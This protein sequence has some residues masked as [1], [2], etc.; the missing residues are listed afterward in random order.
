[1]KKTVILAEIL[2]VAAGFSANAE[3]I[4]KDSLSLQNPVAISPANLINGRISGIKVTST[5]GG[6]NSIIN[7]SIRGVNS[8]RGESEPLWIVDGVVINNSIRQN[9]D[10]FW[11]DFYNG[12]HYS[13]GV[14]GMNFIAPYDIE[15][16]EVLK[17]IS[18]TAIYGSR[19]AN[20]VIIVNTKRGETEKFHLDWHSNVGLNVN[21]YNGISHNHVL[22]GG[23]AHGGNIYSVS[24]FFRT[25][26]GSMPREK[27]NAGG[28]NLKFES[29]ANKLFHFGLNA[30]I[31]INNQNSTSGVARYGA[32]SATI[33]K[34]LQKDFGS[35]GTDFD[36]ETRDYRALANA[37]LD[38]NFTKQLVWRTSMGVSYDNNTR[39]TWYGAGTPIGAE[40]NGAASILA[41]SLLNF[42]LNTNLSYKV[43]ISTWHHLEATAGFEYVRE[44]NIFNNMD[45]ADFFSHELRARGLQLTSEKAVI[46]KFNH[47][48]GHK[49]FFGSLA[50]DYKGIA[51]LSGSLRADNT[52]RYDDS[53]FILYPAGNAW[54]DLHRAFFP[55]FN[56][57]SGLKLTGG[58]GKSGREIYVP[59]LLSGI[60]YTADIALFN[61]ATS[62]AY[63]GFNRITSSEWN[64]GV[65]A[66]FVGNRILFRAK[67]FEK[68]TKD[69][70]QIF[71]FGEPTGDAG[72]WKYIARQTAAD[73]N[74]EIRN[75]GYEFDL[76]VKIINEKDLSWSVN[77][78]ATLLSNQLTKV[79]DE[80]MFGAPICT[81]GSFANINAVGKGVSALYG[82]DTDENGNL[83]DHNGD[84][85]ITPDDRIWL[86]NVQ[87]QF[88]AGLGSSARI[89]RFTADILFD[90]S[91]GGNVLNLGR[92][93][94]EGSVFIT[95][96]QV[97]RND[98]LRCSK[99]SL[100]YAVPVGKIKWLNSLNVNFI[101]NNPF[102]ISGYSGWNPDTDCF[103]VNGF[104]RGIDY[105]TYP[106]IRTLML[107]FSAKF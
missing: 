18:A 87:P 66:S 60:Y 76:D 63:D 79:A 90:A 65:E 15:S 82:F 69:A 23:S 40:K 14:N 9:L 62:P 5:D 86:G 95:K 17:D 101:A 28:L 7:T 43:N 50:Y 91:V 106:I 67:Y 21:G 19:G 105:G 57:V 56:A 35:W 11:Q 89:G 36:D 16:I 54:V 102:T 8:V 47:T 75:R 94:K 73:F 3:N 24:A 100:S 45:G 61:E 51:G 99:I 37:Y 96:N 98:W 13:N 27:A 31:G 29:T 74:S 32:S 81:D 22:Q 20:G 41:S 97:N 48:Y 93:L 58:Y 64:A 1:M 92:M 25:D 70:F 78:N 77:A 107:G 103:G 33:D 52:D 44:S 12:Q 38:V 49:S 88:Y 83:L 85:V 34:Y 30:L 71:C 39:Y 84:G 59:A 6:L 68:K 42:T 55:D 72:N 80:D 10:A 46:R 26:N 104:S 2:L 53:K 4:I